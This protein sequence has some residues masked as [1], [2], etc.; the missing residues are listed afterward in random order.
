MSSPSTQPSL[1]ER[2][3]DIRI[4]LEH[5]VKLYASRTGKNDL[6]INNKTLEL[7]HSYAWARNIRELQNVVER[8]LI[9]T[10]GAFLSVSA[11]RCGHS[12]TPLY[13]P[14]SSMY[15]HRAGQA[16]Y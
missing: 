13:L 12:V 6:S 14:K 8:S 2:K 5:F 4:V 16:L 11:D 10:Q 15:A 7:F 9:L 1:R 3:D